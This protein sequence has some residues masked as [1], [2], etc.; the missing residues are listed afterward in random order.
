MFGLSFANP[1][2]LIGLAAAGVPVLIHLIHRQ[3][4]LVHPFAAIDLVLRT[5]KRLATRL[6]L[7]QLLLLLLRV[8]VVGCIVFALARPF[9]AAKPGAMREHQ[10]TST[11]FVIDSSLSMQYRHKGRSLFEAA[12]AA[13]RSAVEAMSPRDNA[14]ILLTGEF[15]QQ[16]TGRPEAPMALTFGRRSL[17]DRLLS[18]RPGFGS[19]R[20]QAALL[21]ACDLLAASKLPRKNLAFCHDFTRSAWL[22]NEMATLRGRL[23]SVEASLTLINVRPAESLPNAAVLAVEATRQPG[24]GGRSFRVSARVTAAE[25]STRCHVDVDGTRVA[26]GFVQPSPSGPVHKVFDLSLGGTAS[27]AAGS[28]TSL[29]RVQLPQDALAGDDVRHF[30][31]RSEPSIRVLLVDGAPGTA[32]HESETFY[33]ERALAP[34][35]D[36]ES[37]VR[38][39]VLPAVALGGQALDGFDV[40]A[41][42]NVGQWPAAIASSLSRYVGNGGHVLVTVGDQVAV[43][44]VNRA[45]GSML[46]CALR[47]AKTF[48]EEPLRLATEGV[49]HP[50]AAA[51]LT[52]KKSDAARAKFSRIVVPD[53]QLA[54]H[55]EVVLHYSNG[56]PALL[57]RRHGRGGVALF[58][59]TV[60]RAWTDLPIRTVF[61]P[62]AQEL[63]RYLAGRW[64]RESRGESLVGEPRPLRLPSHVA[65][66]SVV[67]PDG[68]AEELALQDGPWYKTVVAARTPVPGHY[69]VKSVGPGQALSKGEVVDSFVVNVDA[70][71]SDLRPLKP[72][73]LEKH[74]GSDRVAWVDAR[75]SAGG[76]GSLAAARRSDLSFGFL[77]AALVALMVEA[78]VAIRE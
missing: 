54:E 72:E 43:E 36:V 73:F 19:V 6:K 64:D 23:E 34:S 62:L 57:L 53:S 51:V 18:L 14:A 59:S 3:R 33:L 75:P 2:I 15:S 27:G 66:A 28:G 56:L 55:V 63:M 41:L 11:V 74:L 17:L 47:P 61:V 50:V 68:V 38:V 4:A 10:P 13:A 70:R 29:G 48:D 37:I 46:P 5:Q 40:V 1:A 21:A 39:Q 32:A 65:R 9:Y 44:E 42:C 16:P 52:D 45:W 78:I 49:T 26:Q 69:A 25:R 77:M 71:E 67:G 35:R 8:L 60:D 7:H 31:L 76:A 22:D 24:A 12:Q 30:L 58:T 20:P